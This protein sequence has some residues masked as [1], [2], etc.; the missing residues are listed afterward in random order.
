MR[1][2]LVS[3]LIVLSLCSCVSKKTFEQQAAATASAQQ[4][5]ADLQGQNADLQSR[6]ARLQA[7]LQRQTAD[8]RSCAEQLEVANSDLHRYLDEQ[9]RLEAALGDTRQEATQAA[10]SCQA[11]TE[12]LQAQV[13]ALDKRAESQ[14]IACQARLA[15]IKN[16]CDQ[17]TGALETAQTEALAKADRLQQ[18][19]DRCQALRQELDQ[20]KTACLQQLAG[21]NEER[22]GLAGQV[23]TLQ[24]RLEELERERQRTAAAADRRQAKLA[25]VADRL[26]QGLKQEIAGGQLSVSGGEGRET[27]R[28]DLEALFTGNDPDLKPAG[29]LLVGKIGRLLQGAE[30]LEI[31]IEG[32]GG[33]APVSEELKAGT[34]SRWELTTARA[35][36][37]M[38]S[39]RLQSQMGH[40][41][42]AVVDLGPA[43]VL[44]GAGSE[45]A[46]TG[47]GYVA[48]VLRPR[49]PPSGPSAAAPPAG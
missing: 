10:D 42:L 47:K 37:V 12:R 8:S 25:E 35:V 48:I 30:G 6:V 4:A 43:P 39:L 3:L 27:V 32:H 17:L 5:V 14:R 18:D 1:A 36:Q 33:R 26:R 11:R 15:S 13:T 19:L 45:A 16:T 38:H 46:G 31:D 29:E 49:C 41:R 34:P 22:E 20:Q 23:A 21:A 44:P 9:Q 7:D 24:P 40:G 2:T 28:I